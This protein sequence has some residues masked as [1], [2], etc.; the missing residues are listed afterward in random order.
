MRIEGNELM[1]RKRVPVTLSKRQQATMSLQML[2]SVVRH[3][4]LIPSSS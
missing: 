3:N 2:N 1:K 4:A